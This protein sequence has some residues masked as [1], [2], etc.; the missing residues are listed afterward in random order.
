MSNWMNEW[1]NELLFGCP[2]PGLPLSPVPFLACVSDK[3]PG[4]W[5][6]VDSQRP[7]GSV[8]PRE[9]KVFTSSPLHSLLL[10]TKTLLF[11]K[12][13]SSLGFSL[14]LQGI[15]LGSLQSQIISSNSARDKALR[16]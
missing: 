2:S 7:V 5:T 4:S 12:L 1:M 6:S 9:L 3:P 11:G 10:M 16:E 8:L 13:Q 15:H 14:P